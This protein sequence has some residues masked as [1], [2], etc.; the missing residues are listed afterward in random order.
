V[1]ELDVIAQ[2]G[3][4]LMNSTSP[5]L[6][7]EGRSWTRQANRGLGEFQDD[8]HAA[9]ADGDSITFY[10]DG[11]DVE[12][13]SSRGAGRGLVDFHVDGVFQATVNLALHPTNRARVFAVSG[14]ARGPHTLRGVKRGG[15]IRGA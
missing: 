12:V 5:V 6:R 2:G 7:Y 15:M 13:I 3:A 14:L 11:T 10:F 1:I 8:V 9:T 4:G